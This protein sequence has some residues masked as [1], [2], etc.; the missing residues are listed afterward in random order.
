[1]R[2]LPSIE[3]HAEDNLA[4]SCGG[5]CNLAIAGIHQEPLMAGST[6]F[7]AVQ[8]PLW[9]KPMSRSEGCYQA[10]S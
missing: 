6:S 3:E 5:R 7:P 1:M 2:V 4:A 10:T 9:V 8:M